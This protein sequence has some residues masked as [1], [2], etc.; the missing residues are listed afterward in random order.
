MLLTLPLTKKRL[1]LLLWSLFFLYRG[2]NHDFILLYC[3]HFDNKKIRLPLQ[4]P[5]KYFINLHKIN[6]GIFLECNIQILIPAMMEL[7][8]TFTAQKHRPFKFRCKTMPNQVDM[9]QLQLSIASA[10]IAIRIF[11]HENPLYFFAS[12]TKMTISSLGRN[13]TSLLFHTTTS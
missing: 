4:E 3:E 10:N 11:L 8:V 7:P 12:T 9:M 6:V 13:L 5:L 1:L 2:T